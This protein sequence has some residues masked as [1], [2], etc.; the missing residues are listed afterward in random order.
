VPALIFPGVLA[1]GYYYYF[2]QPRE[3]GTLHY[4]VGGGKL[5]AKCYNYRIA[6]TNA[7]QKSIEERQAFMLLEFKGRIVDHT[8]S[9]T[10]PVGTTFRDASDGTVAACTGANKCKIMVGYMMPSGY[11]NLTF[12]ARG[13]LSGSPTLMLGGVQQ[14]GSEVRGP[15]ISDGFSRKLCES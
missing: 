4:T 10:L 13:A 12:L 8:D 7:G 5:K 1:V 2:E 14:G 3:R 6:I 11:A 15:R 9:R